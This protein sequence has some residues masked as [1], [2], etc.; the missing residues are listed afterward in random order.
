[1]VTKRL[2]VRGRMQPPAVCEAL[3]GEAA[4]L[5]LKGWVQARLDGGVEAILQGDMEV[6]AAA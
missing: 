2:I 5:G 4:A 1:M 3:P 6:L